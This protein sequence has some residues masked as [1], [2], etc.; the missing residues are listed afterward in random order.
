MDAVREEAGG[1]GE[2]WR[3]YRPWTE[4]RCRNARDESFKLRRALVLALARFPF[5]CFSKGGSL[6]NLGNIWRE[7]S[8]LSTPEYHWGYNIIR[9]SLYYEKDITTALHEYIL[10]INNPCYWN[11]WWPGKGS[12]SLLPLRAPAACH[13]ERVNPAS[14][15]ARSDGSA[16]T[17]LGQRLSIHWAPQKGP[18]EQKKLHFYWVHWEG[19]GSLTKG[20]TVQLGRRG[21]LRSHGRMGS[22][23]G[24]G[25]G[26]CVREG[27]TQHWPSVVHSFD[28]IR[29]RAA[30]C[31]WHHAH[32]QKHSTNNELYVSEVDFNVS[33]KFNLN[34]SGLWVYR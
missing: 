18:M 25:W 15:R 5:R 27:P 29:G 28:R 20:L 34:E 17:T 33:M 21:E 6:R 9:I 8:S 14:G 23:V 30:R 12:R 3:R 32:S 19:R 2:G 24:K 7:H 1:A 11:R 13:G 16:A 22:R 31:M 4:T 26:C 10:D